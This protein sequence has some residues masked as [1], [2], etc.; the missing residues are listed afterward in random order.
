MHGA[1]VLPDCISTD[2]LCVT[3]LMVCLQA[4]YWM[5]LQEGD[6][7]VGMGPRLQAEAYHPATLQ[8]AGEEGFPVPAAG[9][10]A[11]QLAAAT[12]GLSPA[13]LQQ[14]GPAAE[15]STAPAWQ[16]AAGTAEVAQLPGAH[17]AAN[18]HQAATQ[19]LGALASRIAQQ[20]KAT[21]WVSTQPL[22]STSLPGR[23]SAAA[24]GG[25]QARQA[26]GSQQ[27]PGSA[28][29]CRAAS[30]WR[31]GAGFRLA[32]EFAAI[33]ILDVMPLR[34]ADS[35]Q[36]NLSRLPQVCRAQCL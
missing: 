33:T 32:G 14:D 24:G 15:Q 19:G 31:T 13:V 26:P 17:E 22:P 10:P 4:R 5:V 25:S 16:P 20:Q 29:S 28:A 6:P 18:G 2:A 21:T 9:P 23:A 36:G 7:L 12:S 35:I 34:L 30:A 3:E 27:G 1:K 8:L 11:L